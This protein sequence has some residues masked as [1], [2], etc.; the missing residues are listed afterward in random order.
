[1][2][3]AT[4]VLLVASI[5]GLLDDYHLFGGI[6]FLVLFVLFVYFFYCCAKKERDNSKKI[7]TGKTA[8]NIL[9]I[10]LGIIAVIAGAW[11]LIE[12]AVCIADPSLSKPAQVLLPSPHCLKVHLSAQ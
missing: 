10:I 4:V 1:M 9:F 8:K 11:L 5:L 2:L 6:L 12:S 7:N 3:G